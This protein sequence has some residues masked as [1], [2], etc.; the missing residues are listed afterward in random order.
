MSRLSLSDQEGKMKITV[1]GVPNQCQPGCLH[2]FAGFAIF[3]AGEI[4]RSDVSTTHYRTTIDI[5]SYGSGPSES[6][7]GRRSKTEAP[8]A[9]APAGRSGKH[10]AHRQLFGSFLF[11]GVRSTW[12]HL[13]AIQRLARPARRWSGGDSDAGHRREDDRTGTGYNPLAGSPGTEEARAPGT[14]FR[15]PPTGS[16]LHH[17]ARARSLARTR[18]PR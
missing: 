12:H 18:H 16:L 9:F 2:W 6:K 1:L 15:E 3:V 10:P 17:Q 4:A 11:T 5:Y 13:A 7:I 14:P 8:C